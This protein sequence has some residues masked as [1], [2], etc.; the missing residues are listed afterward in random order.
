MLLLT[1]VITFFRIPN[2]TYDSTAGFVGGIFGAAIGTLILV[3]FITSVI[4]GLY[5]HNFKEDANQN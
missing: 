2:I 1:S 4:R 3:Y 5:I